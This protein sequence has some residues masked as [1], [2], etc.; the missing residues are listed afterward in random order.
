MMSLI[1][2][3]VWLFSPQQRGENVSEGASCFHKIFMKY[4]Q[5]KIMQNWEMFFIKTQLNEIRWEFSFRNNFALKYLDIYVFYIRIKNR[6]GEFGGARPGGQVPQ[7]C[8][9]IVVK[10]FSFNFLL[11]LASSKFW[12]LPSVHSEWKTYTVFP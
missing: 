12:D 11:L 6:A 10:P 9:M 5:I 4:S 7:F 1:G 2:S 8:Y 3:F